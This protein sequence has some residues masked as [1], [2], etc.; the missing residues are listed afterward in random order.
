MTDLLPEPDG[1]RQKSFLLLIKI[2]WQQIL[3]LECR[4]DACAPY[5]RRILIC[6]GLL[7]LPCWLI[8]DRRDVF[9]SS[10]ISPRKVKT[11]DRVQLQAVRASL[12]RLRRTCKRPLSSLRS[13]LV[14]CLALVSLELGLYA[15]LAFSRPS[16]THF[17]INC[18]NVGNVASCWLLTPLGSCS[19]V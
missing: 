18:P 12:S 13:R 2:N 17:Q 6:L 11:A 19:P 5:A 8:S 7:L 9:V 3:S 4:L 15:L 16:A 14:T 10:H 1:P